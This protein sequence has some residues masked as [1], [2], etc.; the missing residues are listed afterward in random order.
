ML[1]AIKEELL[2]QEIMIESDEEIVN[3]FNGNFKNVLTFCKEHNIEIIIDD[4]EKELL[5]TFVQSNRPKFK[6]TIDSLDDIMLVHK[7][8]GV[9]N[10]DK[11]VPVSEQEYD[12]KLS[13]GKSDSPKRT[14]SIMVNGRNKSTEI[15]VPTG[16]ST[17]H[18]CMNAE[19]RDHHDSSWNHCDVIVMQPFTEKL[20]ENVIVTDP[21]D[22]FFGDEMDLEGHIIICRDKEKYEQ[23]KQQNPKAIVMQL[24]K[25][26]I[27]FGD[28]ICE[29]MGLEQF[30]SF[31]GGLAA[32]YENKYSE[33]L[34]RSHPKLKTYTHGSTNAFVSH[35]SVHILQNL[36]SDITRFR[37]FESEI[38]SSESFEYVISEFQKNNDHIISSEASKFIAPPF[39][40]YENGGYRDRYIYSW[41]KHIPEGYKH[42]GK[43]MD[44]IKTMDSL[45]PEI[46]FQF[47]AEGVE[48][49]EENKE[50]LIN[51]KDKTIK[52]INEYNKKFNDR[53]EKTK[54]LLAAAEFDK[55]DEKVK[56]DSFFKSYDDYNKL[57][58]NLIFY[59][60]VA[61][62]KGM[63]KRQVVENLP[64]EYYDYSEFLESGK[65]LGVINDDQIAY[66]FFTN[67]QNKI[68]AS[69]NPR[70][71]E[72][73]SDLLKLKE[74]QVLERE[75]AETLFKAYL[76]KK[77]LEYSQETLETLSSIEIAYRSGNIDKKSA[78]A[79]ELLYLQNNTKSKEQDVQKQDLN[80]ITIN[81]NIEIASE[82]NQV[83]NK[84]NKIEDQKQKE[85]REQIEELQ[86]LKQEVE[87]AKQQ[88][89]QQEIVNS[90]TANEFVEDDS[91]TIGF[92]K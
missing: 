26:E 74:E 3:Y 34:L 79:W 2:K 46:L 87:I 18:F 1:Q 5:D 82:K 81:S 30:Y 12:E 36:M 53:V 10:D 66:D 67:N 15:E 20:Y 50:S 88:K 4:Q 85:K 52:S 37:L 72:V 16:H 28:K 23:A 11:I 41:E 80:E 7:T 77:G 45:D 44:K 51:I 57:I 8:T 55:I 69:L 17:T 65:E 38:P 29:A 70:K 49:T 84:F 33:E 27:G 31:N 47:V 39:V 68:K 90:Q 35:E 63:L 14:V 13:L 54:E 59:S 73:I 22:T 89:M 32:S 40:E 71:D 61:H 19:V 86:K 58:N 43:L 78:M 24:P 48:V 9:P 25:W 83:M 56:E 75:Q 42:L 91:E 6:G 92:S 21:A 64:V 62:N 60:E 76:E